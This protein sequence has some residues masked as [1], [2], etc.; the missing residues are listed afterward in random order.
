M[1]LPPVSR[2]FPGSCRLKP[3]NQSNDSV[4][5]Y[6]DQAIFRPLA[7]VSTNLSLRCQL[8]NVQNAW[9]CLESHVESTDRSDGDM[10]W[11]GYIIGHDWG[12]SPMDTN[13]TYSGII[14]RHGKW[15]GYWA[16]ESAANCPFDW[17]A[18]LPIQGQGS[19][20]LLQQDQQASAVH[21]WQRRVE[22]KMMVQHVTA[23]VRLS[24]M[25]Y[26]E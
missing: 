25:R 22:R 17:G 2:I 21:R 15:H 12:I 7:N 5:W 23:L 11:Y 13:G 24:T 16:K 14:F 18:R 10:E 26:H 8:Q 6:E 1:L 4:P 9:R 3:W 19:F 20:S